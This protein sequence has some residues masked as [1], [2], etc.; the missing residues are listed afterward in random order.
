MPPLSPVVVSVTVGSGTVELV[1]VASVV[2]VAAV[3]VVVVGSVV[4]AVGAVV[5]GAVVGAV[6]T[7]VD[8]AAVVWSPPPSAATTAS[9]IASPSTVATRATIAS[10]TPGLI[11][12]LG[13]SP[14]GPEG[15]TSM[16]RVGSSCIAAR[17]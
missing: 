15:G 13:G 12:G 3:A 5:E 6:E 10:F 4:V 2:V 16:R 17:V 14:A 1:V 7:L 8:G 11:P 9:A